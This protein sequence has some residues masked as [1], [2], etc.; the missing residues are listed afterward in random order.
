M[1]FALKLFLVSVLALVLGACATDTRDVPPEPEL[2]PQPPTEPAEPI[3]VDRVDPAD[4]AD[5]RNLDNPDSTLSQREIYFEFDRSNV[6]AEYLP[7]LRAHADYLKANRSARMLLEGH[8]DERGSREYNL[9]L[10]ERRGQ[11]VLDLM[12]AE[13]ASSS[14]IEVVSYGE[15]RPVC[16]QSSESCWERNRR[17]EIV[18]TAR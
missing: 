1:N 18:Y 6:R 13:G 10:G 17:V 4:Y 16:R 8:A 2:Q 9:S 5:S 12:Q 11:S 14:Q 3:E 7:I 15:E